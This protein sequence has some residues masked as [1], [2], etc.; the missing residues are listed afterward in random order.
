MADE[1]IIVNEDGTRT[2]EAGV[3]IAN[4]ETL[5][6][7][8]RKCPNCGG[9]MDFDPECGKLHCP[10]CDYQEVIPQAE[11]APASAVE[12]DFLSAENKETNCNWGTEKKAVVCKS[13]GAE[14]IYDALA[15]S[16]ECPYCGSNQV[17][18]AAGEKTLAPGGVVPF[19]IT[20]EVAGAN[21]KQWI[22][23]KFFCPKLAKES[24]KPE[25]FTGIYLPYWTFDTSTVSSYTGKYGK[26]RTVKRKDSNGNTTTETVTDWFKT[27]G[28]YREDFDDEL[29]LATNRHDSKI[30]NALAP[31][32]TADNK[33]YKPE[34]V[35][36][37]AAER[38]TLGLKDGWEVAK[39]SITKKINS[40]VSGKILREHNADH[41]TDL[42]IK[43]TY[44][45]ITYKYL[46]LPIW[47]SSFQYNGKVYQFMVNG[48]TGKVYGKTPVSAWKV[49]LVVLLVILAIALI[50]GCGSIVG[51]FDNSG[52]ISGMPIF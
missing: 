43:S 9:T 6:E 44:N 41:V 45:K 39:K 47:V 22:K 28:I 33:S 21:F 30:L 40:G 13:C 38:Y 16:S 2:D 24:A 51:F 10:Y 35:A 32:D 48:Q 27:S 25:S 36:G 19:K 18:E 17:M 5:S 20:N 23:K 34:Y 49:I 11:N 26:D 15:V 37:F 31:F 1:N 12:L 3:N 52:F 4:S 8:D 42:K 50:C 46:M 7:T 14:T 29:V